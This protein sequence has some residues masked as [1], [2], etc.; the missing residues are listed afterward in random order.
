MFEDY[1]IDEYG[2]ISLESSQMLNNGVKLRKCGYC[3][4]VVRH[5]SVIFEFV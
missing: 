3:G 5:C 1:E 4:I 2:D